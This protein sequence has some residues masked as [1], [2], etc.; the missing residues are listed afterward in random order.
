MKAAIEGADPNNSRR[1][2]SARRPGIQFIDIPEF[3]K[4]RDRCQPVGEQRDRRQTTIDAALDQGQKL[5][6]DVAAKYKEMNPWLAPTRG[7]GSHAEEKRPARSGDWR[8]MPGAPGDGPGPSDAV[9]VLFTIG[10]SFHEL[11]CLLPR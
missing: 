6:E 4:P 8:G 9:A 10:A 3:P 2:R 5:A 1:S 7:Q 11:E